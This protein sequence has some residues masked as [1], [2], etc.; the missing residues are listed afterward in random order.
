MRVE[1][2]HWNDNAMKT[3]PVIFRGRPG[4]TLARYVAF[5]D[6]SDTKAFLRRLDQIWQELP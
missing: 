5:L 3:T 2:K 6:D 4:K 1:I